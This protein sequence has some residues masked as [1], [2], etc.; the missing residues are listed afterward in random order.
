[1]E[2]LKKPITLIS[3]LLA[4]IGAVCAILFAANQTSE[5]LFDV[6]FWI[7]VCFVVLGLVAIV[8][9]LVMQIVNNPKSGRSLALVLCMLVVAFIIA[10]IFAR[11]GT[12]DIAMLEKNN[13]DPNGSGEKMI[14]AGCIM[15]YVLVAVSA[16]AI[17]YTEVAKIF[18]K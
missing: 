4:V 10:I 2:K 15:V 12:T 8:A 13:I 7:V 3:L 9:F 14:A 16:I 18:K 17:I 11:G 6:A 5:W 1:M